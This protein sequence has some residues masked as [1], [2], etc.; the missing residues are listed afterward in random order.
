MGRWCRSGAAGCHQRAYERWG[1]HG[2][3]NH[4]KRVPVDLFDWYR[5]NP[6][7]DILIGC[8]RG[9]TPKIRVVLMVTI[10]GSTEVIMDG[11]ILNYQT[12][13]GVNRRN[14]PDYYWKNLTA[15]MDIIDFDG[16]PTRNST[17]NTCID[18]SWQICRFRTDP[19]CDPCY[20]NGHLNSLERI[21][22]KKERILL[23]K[24]SCRRGRAC[25][26]SWT[27]A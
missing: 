14:P 5:I 24:I 2:F 19:C 9:A 21:P 7:E 17:W 15:L 27:R 3:R 16:Y 18:H 23:C 20:F 12:S 11:V 13:A 25:F 10:N 4:S 22:Q 1:N 26:L 8:R 6:S